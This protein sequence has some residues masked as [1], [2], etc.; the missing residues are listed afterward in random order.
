M[1]TTQVTTTTSAKP[2]PRR[3]TVVASLAAFQPIGKCF[4]VNACF[5]G[6][7]GEDGIFLEGVEDNSHALR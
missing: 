4:A 7:A 2:R 6:C 5:G 1:Q 3:V